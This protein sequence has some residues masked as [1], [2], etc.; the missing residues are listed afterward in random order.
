MLKIEPS[1]LKKYNLIL[2]SNLI[3]AKEH[4]YYVKWLRYYLDF[5][6]KYGFRNSDSDSL[7]RFIEKLKSKKQNIS[8][9]QQALNAVS[10]FYSLQ[11]TIHPERHNQTN[12]QSN[13]MVREDEKKSCYPA[14]K[15]KKDDSENQ[16][17]QNLIVDLR[18]QKRIQKG[19]NLRLTH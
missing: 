15:T 13:R 18:I 7:P 11:K 12:E 1:L 16:K 17:W 2:Q 10:L 4:S 3:P 14:K 5:C 9:Q 6:H 8:Q 19:S